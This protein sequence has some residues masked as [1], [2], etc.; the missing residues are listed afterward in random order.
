MPIVYDEGKC[1][2]LPFIIYSCIWNC[3]FGFGFT[4]HATIF[5]GVVVGRAEQALDTHLHVGDAPAVAASEF[6]THGILRN[7]LSVF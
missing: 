4:E 7:K 6:A 5:P 3:L 1:L 2:T